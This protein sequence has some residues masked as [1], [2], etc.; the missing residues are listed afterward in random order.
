MFRDM[1]LIILSSSSIKS[2]SLFA[3]L[4]Q[5]KVLDDPLQSKGF[6]SPPANS[7]PPAGLLFFATSHWVTLVTGGEVFQPSE[8]KP[9]LP[10][11]ILDRFPPGV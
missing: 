1:H 10:P 7:Q 11:C 3:S 9:K 5:N 2:L 8:S 4:W 6:T